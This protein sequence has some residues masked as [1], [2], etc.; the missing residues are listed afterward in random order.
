MK[1]KVV[2]VK[3][4]GVLVFQLGLQGADKQALKGVHIKFPC[5]TAYSASIYLYFGGRPGKL[6]HDVT[7][8][9]VVTS[10]PTN[11]YLS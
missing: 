9:A 1:V 6:L 3:E 8:T 7:F 4:S 5:D 10:D 11:S 2:G